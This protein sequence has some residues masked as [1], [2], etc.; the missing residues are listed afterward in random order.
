MADDSAGDGDQKVGFRPVRLFMWLVRLVAIIAGIAVAFGYGWLIYE[1]VIGDA[2]VLAKAMEALSD[3]CYI[4]FTVATILTELNI[5]YFLHEFSFLYTW[6]GRGILQIFIAV[7]FLNSKQQ[8]KAQG[9][10]SDLQDL[11][12]E[13]V[14]DALL[15]SGGLYLLMGI[16]CMRGLTDTSAEQRKKRKEFEKELHSRSRK[17]KAKQSSES[18]EDADPEAPMRE[19]A[20]P[21][22]AK[23]LDT[24]SDTDAVPPHSS[25]S[26]APATSSS[27][28]SAPPAPE[29]SDY[30]YK[31]LED[32]AD[33]VAAASPKTKKKGR[34]F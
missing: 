7:D 27:K 16:G 25:K 8:I 31:A 24:L 15:A 5:E 33:S 2:V 21:S 13:S 18:P 34:F 12:T 11:I 14:G 29:D 22:A 20:T 28:P 1:T 4:L 6:P 30:P 23:H 32:D 17:K 26:P 9:L 3:L 10:D 19:P